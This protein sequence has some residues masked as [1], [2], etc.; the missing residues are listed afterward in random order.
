MPCEH[1]PSLPLPSP[2][3]QTCT[4]LLHALS[5]RPSSLSPG[6]LPF[7]RPAVG[8][9]LPTP[10]H[11]SP[12]SL[13]AWA[14]PPPPGCTQGQDC[15]AHTA[16]S[17]G[18]VFPSSCAR[19]D[20]ASRRSDRSQQSARKSSHMWGPRGGAPGYGRD[21]GR[22]EVTVWMQLEARPA[23]SPRGFGAGCTLPADNCT[24]GNYSPRNCPAGAGGWDVLHPH[25]F[26][27][28]QGEGKGLGSVLAAPAGAASESE[29][30]LSV[31]P[32]PARLCV[33]ASAA[34][35]EHGQDPR[36]GRRGGTRVPGLR[37]RVCSTTR[38]PLSTRH[39][40]R[41]R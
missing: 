35:E 7:C 26:P 38:C 40:A 3:P 27:G 12:G 36:S 10:M 14:R 19:T 8:G 2:S 31:C 1:G 22:A 37:G 21:T 15:S 28:D 9:Y 13:Q 29:V 25:V 34:R 24:R 32:S 11:L 23:A 4:F 16:P 20:P 41:L 5:L 33:K 6:P 30:P 39:R 18:W 17:P